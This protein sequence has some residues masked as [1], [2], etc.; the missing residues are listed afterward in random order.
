LRKNLDFA[1]SHRYDRQW[2]LK[3][4]L[5]L[6]GLEREL[7]ARMNTLVLHWHYSAA[8]LTDWGDDKL[9]EY[10]MLKAEETFNEVGKH[11][12]PWYSQWAESEGTRLLELWNRFK[13]EEKH[14]NF[15]KWRAKTKQEMSQEAKEAEQEAADLEL[16]HARRRQFMRQQAERQARRR[17][18]ARLR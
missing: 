12:L 10:H 14:P 1:R 4:S 17:T 2:L 13:E 16:A 18:R 3:E 5:V 7:A 9:F 6:E 15:Q 11:Y 8:Q